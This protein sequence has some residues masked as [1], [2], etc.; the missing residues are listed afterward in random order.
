MVPC[1]TTCSVSVN[2]DPV[3]TNDSAAD[4]TVPADEMQ[5]TSGSALPTSDAS[6]A[7]ASTL[8]PAAV[9]D[10]AVDCDSAVTDSSSAAVA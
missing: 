9:T 1:D 4:A 6:S 7:A 5:D 10:A 3:P 8:L 2:G